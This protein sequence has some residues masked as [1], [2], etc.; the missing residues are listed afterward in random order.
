MSIVKCGAYLTESFP[1][2]RRCIFLA[3]KNNSN[4][5]TYWS[6]VVVPKTPKSKGPGSHLEHLQLNEP[7]ALP[8]CI[9][10]HL[11]FN[12]IEFAKSLHFGRVEL[13]IRE[14][15]RS[16]GVSWWIHSA[17]GARGWFS[18][19]LDSGFRRNDGVW[20]QVA[21]EI[22]A[23][24]C[25][26]RALRQKNGNQ[27]AGE[28]RGDRALAGRSGCGKVSGERPD[29]GQAVVGESDADLAAQRVRGGHFA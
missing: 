29:D 14:R 28:R 22:V 6:F 25:A 23:A 3:S 20:G 11:L 2:N 1:S 8:S 26:N 9:M 7:C 13:L 5:S 19:F 15:R 12:Q 21:S 27:G 24:S 17:L 18:E 16:S 10:L 4:Q